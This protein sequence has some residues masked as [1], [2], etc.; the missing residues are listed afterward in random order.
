M[1]RKM[2][3][4]KPVHIN[5]VDISKCCSVEEDWGVRLLVEWHLVFWACHLW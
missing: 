1:T 2:S 5:L 4:V 3:K